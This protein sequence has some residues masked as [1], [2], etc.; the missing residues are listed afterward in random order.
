MLA[1]SPTLARERDERF[2]AGIYTR[3]AR[4]GPCGSG[5]P[6]A[7]GGAGMD[8]RACAIALAALAR[9][10]VGATPATD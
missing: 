3:R 10:P 4:L 8:T 9:G 5:I 2:P 1:R 7:Q 6:A